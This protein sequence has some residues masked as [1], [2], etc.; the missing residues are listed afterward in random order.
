MINIT[1]LNEVHY[2]CFISGFC[3]LSGNIIEWHNDSWVH[4]S[5][6][7]QDGSCD[8]LYFKTLFCHEWRCFILCCILSFCTVYRQD[9]SG[10]CVFWMLWY[11][12]L[13]LDDD[14][15]YVDRH[16]NIKSSVFVIQFQN[17]ARVYFAFP[18]SCELITA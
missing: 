18:I 3:F 17:H 15:G 2:L 14:M 9:V 11:V 5:C 6:I 10:R 7:V 16:G 12:M 13:E 8:F 1:N 4:L